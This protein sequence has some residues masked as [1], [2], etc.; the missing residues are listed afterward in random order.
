MTITLASQFGSGA[1]VEL[2]GSDFFG[3]FSITTGTDAE[4]YGAVATLTFSQYMVVTDQSMVLVPLD[5]ASAVLT[6]QAVSQ[7]GVPGNGSLLIQIA[8]TEENPMAPNTTYSWAYKV[9]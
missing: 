6:V 9:G 2:L 1:T 5:Q 4:A 3:G 8:G 7:G